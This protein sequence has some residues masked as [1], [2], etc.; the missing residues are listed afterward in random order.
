MQWELLNNMFVEFIKC[1]RPFKRAA[2]MLMW[3]TVKMS[4]TP[5]LYSL[6]WE[7]RFFST[8]R[9]QSVFISQTLRDCK[10]IDTIECV[11][12]VRWKDNQYLW[13][14]T[15]R[16][17]EYLSSQSSARSPWRR[18]GRVNQLLQ[19]GPMLLNGSGPTACW[20]MLKRSGTWRGLVS[21]TTHSL[22]NH[23]SVKQAS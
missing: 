16:V 5:L 22:L 15:W 18:R 7:W 13:S 2:M 17:Y 19:K 11:Q 4:L 6:R 10:V 23:S 3:P 14:K 1:F 12:P 20:L 21:V 8:L 9:K